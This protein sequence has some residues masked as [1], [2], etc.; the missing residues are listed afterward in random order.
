MKERV[1]GAYYENGALC[2]AGEK[3]LS[4]NEMLTGG[5]HNIQNALSAIAVAKLMGVE[6]ET[7]R[8]ALTAFKGIKHRVQTVG[9]VDGVTYINDSKGT[10]VDA[11]V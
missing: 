3:I 5:L 7:I 6:T 2:F 8:T 11:T 1:N 10:N 4:A 9:T